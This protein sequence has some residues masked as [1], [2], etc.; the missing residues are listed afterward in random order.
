[1][2]EEPD[3]LQSGKRY[4]VEHEGHSLEHR[5][6]NSRSARPNPPITSGEEGG[7]IPV[8]P[9]TP[10]ST[11]GKQGNPTVSLQ[12]GSSSHTPPSSQG[13]SPVQQ[14]QPPRR[15]TMVDDIK[16]PI[17]RGTGLEDPEHIG[18]YAKLCGMS[19]KSKMMQLRWHN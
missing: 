18:S 3:Y 8:R 7:L 1:M 2:L 9:T 17:F 10:Q 19:S 14:P 15:N 5:P 12:S 16:L 6:G 4:R 11:L 13:T